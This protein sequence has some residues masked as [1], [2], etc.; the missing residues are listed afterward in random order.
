ML[1]VFVVW[2]KQKEQGGGRQGRTFQPLPGGWEAGEIRSASTRGLVGREEQIRPPHR[3]KMFRGNR[4]ASTR[5]VGGRGEQFNLL[6]GWEEGEN[7]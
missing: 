2:F 4:S 3:G 5:G 7:R 6:A 1:P